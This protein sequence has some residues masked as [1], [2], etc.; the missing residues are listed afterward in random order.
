MLAASVA[1]FTAVLAATPSSE[2]IVSPA[3]LK[4]RMAATGE[5]LVV[6]EASWTPSLQAATDYHA[7]HI[8]GAIHLNTDELEN[9]YPRWRLRPLAEL[10]NV[11]GGLGIGPDTAVVVSE[12]L[13]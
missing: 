10:H 11:I 13:Q 1:L 5:R 2:L 4:G 3:W 12:L 8:P 7:G 6:I 9:G